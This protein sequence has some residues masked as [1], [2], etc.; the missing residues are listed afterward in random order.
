MKNLETLLSKLDKKKEVFFREYKSYCDELPSKRNTHRANDTIYKDVEVAINYSKF[1]AYDYTKITKTTI[2]SF[3]SHLVSKG[4][5]FSK[6]KRFISFLFEKELISQKIYAKVMNIKSIKD[7]LNNNKEKKARIT[8]DKWEDLYSQL[9]GVKKFALWFMFNTGVRVNEL[10]Y[11]QL[12]DIHI[13]HT[14]REYYISIRK[15]PE[16]G[17]YPKTESSVRQIDLRK[18]E[19]EKVEE[20]LAIREEQNLNHDFLIYNIRSNRN[21]KDPY[22]KRILNTGTVETWINS[23]KVYDEI[24]KENSKCKVKLHDHMKYDPY[25]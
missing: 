19:M 13:D 15:K 14:N 1:I 4:T 10:V 17:F 20:Y 9:S 24:P 8:S 5:T 23:V 6:I 18:Q 12:S 16:I 25:D 21:K 2:D 3:V 22:K 11:L 7:E